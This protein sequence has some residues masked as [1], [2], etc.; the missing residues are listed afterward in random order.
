MYLFYRMKKKILILLAAAAIV[1]PVTIYF[2]LKTTF[3]SM[4][5]HV[6][7][8]GKEGD[9]VGSYLTSE[10]WRRNMV[11]YENIL[12]RLDGK[13]KKILVIFG[14]GHTALL[15]ELMKYNKKFELVSVRSIF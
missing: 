6:N 15:C 10:S 7:Q 9:H 2:Q 3:T 5:D 12:K 8:A 1:L 11:I 13:E 4:S 14:S